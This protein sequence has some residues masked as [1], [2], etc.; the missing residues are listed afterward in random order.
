[1]MCRRSK[2]ESGARAVPCG[3]PTVGQKIRSK[4]GQER[5]LDLLCV[6]VAVDIWLTEANIL[7]W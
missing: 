6:C 4:L 2:K 5:R 1:M 7:I 3:A